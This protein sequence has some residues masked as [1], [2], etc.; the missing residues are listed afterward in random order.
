MQIKACVHCH[1][2]NNIGEKSTAFNLRVVEQRKAQPT[3][4]E[5]LQLW[6]NDFIAEGWK[7][8]NDIWLCPECRE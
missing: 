8:E 3:L 7:E 4:L 2:C 5:C 6:R 1:E